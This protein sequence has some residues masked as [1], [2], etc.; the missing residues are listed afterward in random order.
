MSDGDYI[1]R[2][3]ICAKHMTGPQ[4][5]DGP[6]RG[7]TELDISDYVCLKPG[8][9]ESGVHFCGYGCRNNWVI[10]NIMDKSVFAKGIKVEAAGCRRCVY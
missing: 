9:S 6:E 3:N 5:C 10:E 2:C 1:H 4:M 7:D 8:E